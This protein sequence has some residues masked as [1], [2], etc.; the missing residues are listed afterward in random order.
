MKAIAFYLPQF[1]PIPENDAAWGRGFTEW[2]NVAKA[3]KL[4]P[5]H[6]QPKLPGELGFYDL[7]LEEVQEAQSALALRSGITGFAYW[8]Y[9]MGNDKRLLELPLN[10]M[11]GNKNI[12]IDFCLAWANESWTGA[13]HGNPTYTIVSQSYPEGDP[14][15]HAKSL[16]R[17]FND[18]RYIRHNNRP[19]FL[20]YKPLQLP[21][22][23]LFDLRRQLKA[24]GHNIYVIA[25]SSYVF[26]YNEYGFD[27]LNLNRLSLLRSSPVLGNIE[28]AVY[29][30]LRKTPFALPRIASYSRVVSTL[31]PIEILQ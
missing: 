6:Y 31:N 23:Y 9:W 2:T 1:H 24:C 12:S 14:L 7:R 27:A 15:S 3:K 30:V 13:W 16:S 11:L 17:Y 20:I 22:R 8:Y 29:G 25:I 10:R 5:R 19:V 28:R 18:P 26:D 4:Y 21:P